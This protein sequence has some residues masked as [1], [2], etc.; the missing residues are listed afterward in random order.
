MTKKQAFDFYKRKCYTN[1][2]L[3]SPCDAKLITS[4]LIFKFLVK[5]WRLFT[6]V[7]I[8][9]MILKLVGFNS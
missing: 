7:F 3:K 4:P 5:N 6:L 9:F 8:N 1:A 2:C